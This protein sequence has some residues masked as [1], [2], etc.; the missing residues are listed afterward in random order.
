MINCKSSMLAWRQ[1]RG[2]INTH[3]GEVQITNCLQLVQNTNAFVIFYHSSRINSQN[4]IEFLIEK[5]RLYRIEI[6]QNSAMAHAQVIS[7]YV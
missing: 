1:L 2:P 4:T 6:Y 7:N 5:C 3:A